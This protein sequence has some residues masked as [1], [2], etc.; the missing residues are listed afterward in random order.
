M[1]DT[2]EVIGYTTTSG[3]SPLLKER[4][5]NT[6]VKGETKTTDKAIVAVITASN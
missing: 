1:S 6:I 4:T 3:S 2:G 5:E